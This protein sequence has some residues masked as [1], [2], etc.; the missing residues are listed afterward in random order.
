MDEIVKTLKAAKKII[1]NPSNWCQGHLAR[2]DRGHRVASIFASEAS[3][4][5][6]Y[7]ALAKICVKPGDDFAHDL[8]HKCL[9][10]MHKAINEIEG[11][12]EKDRSIVIFNDRNGHEEVM[13][14]FDKAIELGKNYV[15]EKT[16]VLQRPTPRNESKSK[17]SRVP[18]RD[19]GREPDSGGRHD[20]DESA[21]PKRQ[22]RRRQDVEEAVS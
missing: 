5:D 4:Y 19:R 13:K 2:D 3:K 21:A 16:E 17:H 20:H 14:L 10:V 11:K 12:D 22:R 6:A 1:Q 15:E 9:Q 18:S 7:G 8:H